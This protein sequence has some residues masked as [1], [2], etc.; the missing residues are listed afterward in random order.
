MRSVSA[1]WTVIWCRI[2]RI[3]IGSLI[4]K[5]EILWWTMDE[6]SSDSESQVTNR[7]ESCT[8]PT[9]S[10]RTIP[11]K[12][13]AVTVQII[14]KVTEILFKSEWPNY[15]ACL[16]SLELTKSLVIKEHSQTVVSKTHS[17]THTHIC[18]IN[19]IM[20]VWFSTDDNTAAEKS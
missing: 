18:M 5:V 13:D 6:A 17:H 16:F 20:K 14:N 12:I 19:Y 11:L 1:I 8:F 9:S 15:E 2:C 10:V 4:W 3:H 7:S